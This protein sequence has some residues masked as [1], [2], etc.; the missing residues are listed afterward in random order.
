ME[1]RTTSITAA[2][3]YSLQQIEQKIIIIIIIM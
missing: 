3:N 2:I 1:L